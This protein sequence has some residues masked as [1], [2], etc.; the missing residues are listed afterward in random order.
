[1]KKN[2][3]T[4]LTLSTV[5]ALTTACSNKSGDALS[6]NAS[7]T[8]SD[9]VS[10]DEQSENNE[11]AF[12]IKYPKSL[13]EAFGESVELEKIPSRIICMTTG[14]VETLYEMGI[15]MMAIPDS[16]TTEWSDDI[17][18]KKLPFSMSDIDIESILAMEPDFVILSTGKKDK[19]GKVLEDNGISTY[20]VKAGPMVLFEDIKNEVKIFGE[21]FN[22]QE[23]CDEILKRFDDI[24][25][26]ME[27]YK[28]NH[29][30]QK[31]AILFGFPPSMTMSS[32]SYLGDIMSKL[33]FDNLSDKNELSKMGESQN[34]VLNMELM[35]D[36]NPE[37]LVACSPGIS[38][39]SVI[40]S[41]FEDEFKKNSAMWKN[42]DAVKNDNILYLGSNFAKSSGIK[43]IDDVDSL[44]D[45]LENRQ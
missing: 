39:A 7:E 21:A 26:R 37:I 18:A 20:Y 1:M 15:D 41:S 42:I 2:L 17:G 24:E 16:I 40:Q 19:Y 32:N 25:K 9:A 35:I 4:I 33:G 34:Y 10:E 14:P 6:E 30:S 31:M 44:L 45:D 36:V 12:S 43:I 23:K 29:K 11:S 22:K 5:M 38:E 8:T 3:L 28:E 13:Y 27:E